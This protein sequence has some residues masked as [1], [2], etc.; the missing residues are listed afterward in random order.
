MATTV[1]RLKYLF[2]KLHKVKNIFKAEKICLLFLKAD[3]K[4]LCLQIW[5]NDGIWVKSKI[6]Q[7]SKRVRNSNQ[8]LFRQY[9]C[10][11]KHQSYYRVLGLQKLIKTEFWLEGIIPGN[12]PFVTNGRIKLKMINTDGGI[13]KV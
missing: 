2:Q 10:N 6:S 1:Q 4:N 3:K 11:E 8:N 13:V 5:G 9:A 7:R 12:L